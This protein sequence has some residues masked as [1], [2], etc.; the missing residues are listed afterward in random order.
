TGKELELPADAAARRPDIAA[1]ERAAFLA[2]RSELEKQLSVLKEQVEQRRQEIREF[3][4]KQ[5]SLASSLRL[6]RQR[7]GLSSQLLKDNLTPKLEHLALQ[8]EVQDLEGQV[9]VIAQSVPRA[10]SALAEA[11]KRVEE[12]T[13]RFRRAAQEGISEAELNIARTRELLSDATDQELRTEVKSPID[14]VVKN[15]RYSTI[16][17]VVKAGEPIMDI[18]PTGDTLIIEARLNPADRGYVREG[19][20]ATVKVSTYDYARYG[21]LEGVVT[22]V[23]PDSTTPDQ[24]TPYFRVLVETSKDYLGAV[25]GEYAITPGMQ[26]TVD[27]H[28]GTRSVLDYLIKPVL[29]LKHEAFRER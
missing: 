29:K 23:A 13:L 10:R 8:S 12:E 4:A 28:T 27:I 24:E 3:E 14:G 16:G 22:H 26:A 6:A 5:T 25:E 2:R 18:V 1:G 19:Q 15:M 17:G 9:A 21:G 11:E 7:L 20:P